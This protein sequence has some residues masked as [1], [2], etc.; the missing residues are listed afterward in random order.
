MERAGIKNNILL[1]GGNPFFLALVDIF[2]IK[3]LPERG[4]QNHWFLRVT[5]LR[6]MCRPQLD[7]QTAASW[8]RM[9]GPF[10]YETEPASRIRLQ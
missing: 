4:P 5:A 6:G 2:S 1:A 9:H 10:G 3:I 8:W 7:I